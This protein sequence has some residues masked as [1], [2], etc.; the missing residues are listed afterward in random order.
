MKQ[1]VQFEGKKMLG[2]KNHIVTG[3]EISQGVF[4]IMVS[5]KFILLVCF[6]A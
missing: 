5:S 6:S 3:D 4:I 1:T 2:E